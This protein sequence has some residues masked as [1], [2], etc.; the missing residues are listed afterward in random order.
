MR[1]HLISYSTKPF[2]TLVGQRKPLFRRLPFRRVRGPSGQWFP[3]RNRIRARQTRGDP[4]WSVRPPSVA[5]AH[6]PI[7]P[8]APKCGSLDRF[9]RRP[10]PRTPLPLT[11]VGRRT[12]GTTARRADRTGK[13]IPH[14]PPTYSPKN[15]EAAR[16]R[17]AAGR[18]AFTAESRGFR[19]HWPLA[20][21]GNNH[22]TVVRRRIEGKE[23]GVALR[24]FE[25][26]ADRYPSFRNE[27]F[28]RGGAT[29]RYLRAFFACRTDVHTRF[30]SEP[31]MYV[32]RLAWGGTR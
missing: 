27:E 12:I 29:R 23:R 15:E 14:L 30:P 24:P 25:R 6:P 9:C 31:F 7:R 16:K 11:R 21:P 1:P 28:R 22:A 4:A 26:L 18:P 3:D 2:R 19:D 13:P 10:L 8:I 5:R 20:P 32:N 17:E